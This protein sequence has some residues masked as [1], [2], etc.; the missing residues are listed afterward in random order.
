MFSNGQLDSL[1][2]LLNRVKCWSLVDVV[3]LWCGAVLSFAFQSQ[4]YCLIFGA[5]VA[6]LRLVLLF[7]MGITHRVFSSL[8]LCLTNVF[9]IELLFYCY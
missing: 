2:S 7:P 5:S 6:S 1:Q 4:C 3:L 9:H 8:C